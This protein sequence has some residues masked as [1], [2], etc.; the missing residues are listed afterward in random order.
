MSPLREMALEVWEKGA[1][2]EK[3]I[4]RI[5]SLGF[6]THLEVVKEKGSILLKVIMLQ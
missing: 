4:L 6:F 2:V 1:T 5:F 3:D